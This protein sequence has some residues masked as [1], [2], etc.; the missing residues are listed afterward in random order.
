MDI[1]VS[2]PCHRIFETGS[3]CQENAIME[4]LKNIHS[5]LINVKDNYKNTKNNILNI[6]IVRVLTILPSD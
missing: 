6:S 3:D 2:V 5:K 1:A 4:N